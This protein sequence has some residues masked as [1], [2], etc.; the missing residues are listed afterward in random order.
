[1]AKSEEEQFESFWEM[2]CPHCGKKLDLEIILNR[3]SKK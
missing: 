2:K 3:F 1:M